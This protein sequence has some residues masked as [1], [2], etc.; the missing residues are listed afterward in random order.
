M[1]LLAKG[2]DSLIQAALGENESAATT[3][4]ALGNTADSR[5]VKLLQS[6]IRQEDYDLELRRL[7]VRSMAKIREGASRLLRAVEADQ[8]DQALLPAAA[9]E[10]TRS[11]WQDLRPQALELFPLPPSKEA[12]PIPPISELVKASGDP[13]AGKLVFQQAGTCAKCHIVGREGKEVGPNLTEIG[14]KLSP[15]AMFESILYPSAGISHNY[16]SYTVA[17]QDGNTITG[18]LTSQTDESITITSDDGIARTFERS[19]V[20]AVKQL[21]VSLMPADLLKLMTQDELVNVVAYLTT[22]KKK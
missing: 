15:E 16:E 7:A 18:L 9:A 1:T 3:I 20:E 14:S 5:G 6:L 17:T 21:T 2:Q 11:R 8:L 22:L 10:L 13:A 12:K 19:N 4:E